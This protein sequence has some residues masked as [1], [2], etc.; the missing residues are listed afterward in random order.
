MNNL[1]FYFLLII[2]MLP[3]FGCQ[4]LN[5]SPSQIDIKNYINN[6]ELFQENPNN[7]LQDPYPVMDKIEFNENSEL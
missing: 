6:F 1:A 5:K 2:T 7:G 3:L 4:K